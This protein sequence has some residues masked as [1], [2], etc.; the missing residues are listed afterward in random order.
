MVGGSPFGT[1]PTR[2]MLLA[3]PTARLVGR[4]SANSQVVTTKPV[5]LGR[6]DPASEV[7]SYGTTHVL[8][9]IIT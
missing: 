7:D 5:V 8:A 6:I 3:R 1:V 9:V 2:W 4:T